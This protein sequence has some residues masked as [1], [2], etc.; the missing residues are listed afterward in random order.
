MLVAI[1]NFLF[2]T[3]QMDGVKFNEVV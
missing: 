1:L 3:I 2:A